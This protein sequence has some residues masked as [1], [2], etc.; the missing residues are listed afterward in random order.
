MKAIIKQ[1][2]VYIAVSEG[3]N[4]RKDIDPI[5][6]DSVILYRIDIIVNG[7]RNKR[8]NLLYGGRVELA[9]NYIDNNTQYVRITIDDIEIFY[10]YN[11]DNI[12][13]SDNNFTFVQT[14]AILNQME[15]LG[16]D[17]FLSNYKTQFQAFKHEVEVMVEKLEQEQ[18]VQ[19]DEKKADRLQKLRD[20]LCELSCEAFLLF[21]NMN[22]GL[23]NQ[24]YINAYD[25]VMSLYF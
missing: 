22:A 20:F 1:D 25:T 2:N 3:K 7:H 12:P 6:D 19:Y 17:T 23:E 13:Y 5:T 10:F 15:N 18:T 16:V 21:V 8:N 9:E 11:D 4:I 24:D 14:A